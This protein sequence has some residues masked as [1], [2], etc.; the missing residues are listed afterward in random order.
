M[1]KE[2]D[3]AAAADIVAG[4]KEEAGYLPRSWDTRR[5]KRA[6]SSS[7]DK[8]IDLTP[9]SLSRTSIDRP[10][11]LSNPGNLAPDLTGWTPLRGPTA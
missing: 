2:V 1:R 9:A 8:L 4:G 5:G 11:V 10:P 7:S 3:A 6:T